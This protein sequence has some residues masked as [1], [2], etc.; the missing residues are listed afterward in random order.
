[1]G[2]YPNIKFYPIDLLDIEKTAELIRRSPHII[3]NATT[4]QSWW[5]VN[6][7]PPAVNANYTETNAPLDLDFNAPALLSK[8]MKV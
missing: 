8:L 6:E 4:L 7:L 2:L 1:M 3:Y 5:V